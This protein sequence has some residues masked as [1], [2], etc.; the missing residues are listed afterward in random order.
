[1]KFTSIGGLITDDFG[2]WTYGQYAFL[3][4]GQQSWIYQGCF[5]YAQSV[6]IDSNWRAARAF[7]AIV[8]FG[9]FAFFLMSVFLA[10]IGN[11]IEERPQVIVGVCLLLLSLFSGL[12]LLVLDSNLCKEN[13]L[14][15]E[16]GQ[17]VFNDRCELST[18][19]NC[20]ISATVFWFLAALCSLSA[21]R[22]KSEE[23]NQ[24]LDELI[25]N[26]IHERV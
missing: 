17:F 18:G 10:C 20:V 19:A 8:L 11:R 6:E 4:T 25:E 5:P 22:S 2:L 7:N 14:L 23:E 13:V 12:T 9:G 24:E 21:S 15:G 26:L 3:T 16:L 1:M